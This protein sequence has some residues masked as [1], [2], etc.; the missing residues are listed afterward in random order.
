MEKYKDARAH[1]ILCKYI[2]EN[3][4][5][6]IPEQIIS[7]INKLNQHLSESEPESQKEAYSICHSEWI[8]LLREEGLT[9]IPD[10]K[11]E[12]RRGLIGRVNSI[13]DDRS[14]CFIN[15][16]DN[17]SF[18]CSKSELPYTINNGDEL[19]FDAIPSYDKKKGKDS[20]RAAN[21]RISN[22]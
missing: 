18:F 9:Q 3:K 8:K 11:R 1:L 15:T 10:N 5:W 14:F 12:I 2:R 13:R 21:I 22:N 6:S 4:G 16:T 7:A 17:Q 20:W 19:H